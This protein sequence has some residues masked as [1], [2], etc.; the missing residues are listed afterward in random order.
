MFLGQYTHN[1]D[2]KGRLTIP[3]KYREA[4]I[5]G[6]YLTK[7]FDRNLMVWTA[8]AFN[9]LEKQINDLSVT[10]PDARLLKRLIFS[11]ALQVELDKLGRILVPQYLRDMVDLQNAAMVVGSGDYFEIWSDKNWQN[12]SEQLQDSESTANRFAALSLKAK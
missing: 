12:Q 5:G 2:E 9:F 4:L 10:D 1:L 3:V 8:A 6:A 11:N 7:G